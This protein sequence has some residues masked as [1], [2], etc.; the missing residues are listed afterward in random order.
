MLLVHVPGRSAGDLVHDLPVGLRDEQRQPDRVPTVPDGDRYR[1]VRTDPHPDRGVAQH[2]V[3]EEDVGGAQ[4]PVVARAAAD[5]RDGGTRDAMNPTD[6]GLLFGRQAVDE[7]QQRRVGCL[8]GSEVGMGRSGQFNTGR[9]AS[10]GETFDRREAE[11]V[12][13]GRHRQ[14]GHAAARA[15]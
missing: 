5:H 12:R 6:Q 3:V 8:F 11:T 7:N 10:G 1:L 14:H 4:S 13:T 9:F 15:R 2:P